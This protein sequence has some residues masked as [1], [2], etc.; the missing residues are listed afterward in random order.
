[1]SF[2]AGKTGLQRLKNISTYRKPAKK[3]LS[4]I[5]ADSASLRSLSWSQDDLC[6]SYARS[7]L[8]EAWC[9]PGMWR[10]NHAKDATIA[11]NLQVNLV[12]YALISLARTLFAYRYKQESLLNEGFG[13]YRQ[14]LLAVQQ[15]LGESESVHRLDLLE[16]ILALRTFDVCLP[17]LTAYSLAN[18]VVVFGSIS[19][20]S[21]DTPLFRH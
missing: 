17:T 16:A 1:M 10:L 9:E 4:P 2:Q 21:L 3:S 14:V 18:Q 12:Q 15:S 7:H 5:W 20:G 6:I 13:L 19:Q 8:P 11:S